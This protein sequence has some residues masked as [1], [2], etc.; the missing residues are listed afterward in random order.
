MYPY[1]VVAWGSRSGYDSET[2]AINAAM[3]LAVEYDVRADV[4]HDRSGRLVRSFVRG[5]NGAAVEVPVGPVG[6]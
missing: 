3:E 5:P 4:E 1:N 2:E 6:G